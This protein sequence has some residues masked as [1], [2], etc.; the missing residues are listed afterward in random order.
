MKKLILF[1]IPLLMMNCTTPETN[2]LLSKW[3][4]PFQTPPFSLIKAEHYMPAF[5]QGIKEKKA[6]ID[7][8]INTTD[9][10]TFENTLVA[11][12]KAG[13]TINRVSSLFSNQTSS[14][15]NDTLQ[16]LAKEIS[17]LLSALSDDI[18][19]N[20]KLFARI[21]AV[22]NQK[23]QLDLNTEEMR[24]LE[25]TYQDF[26]R[27]G[28][29]LPEEKQTRFR[30][31]NSALSLASL[32]FGDHLLA[33]AN[34]FELVVEDK[35]QLD[36][37]PQNEIDAAASAAKAKGQEGKYIFNINRT[38]L[39]P[40]LT[41]ANNRAL[42]EEL[43]RGYFMKGDNDNKNDNK[44]LIKEI[45]NLRLERA[46]MLGFK[47]HAAYTLDN[48]MAKNAKNVYSLLN[49]V[50][51]AA[52][53]AAKAEVVEMQKIIDKEKGHFQL[54]S[55]DWWH[56][57]EKVRQEKYALS[58]EE[59]RP[60]FQVDNVRQGIFQLANKLYGI[61]FTERPDID[62]Y[63]KDVKAYEVKEA[64]GKHIGIFYTDY[65]ARPSKRSGAWM[66][67]YRKQQRINGENVS[68][69]IVNVCNFPEPTENMPSLL[70]FEQ[71]TTVFHEFGHALHG[72]LSNCEF[73]GLSGTSVARDFVELPSQ[74]MENWASQPEMLKLY[75]K[76]YKTGEIMPQELIDKIVKASQF[77]QG[78]ATTE[79]IAASLLD[80]DYHTQTSPIT[81]VNAFEKKS[82]QEHGLI[83]EI[84]PRYRSTYFQHIFS[85]GYSSGYYSY[86][87]AEVLDADAFN[88]FKEN[89][90]FDKKTAQSFRDNIISKGGSDDPMKLYLQ[91]RGTAPSTTPLLERRGLK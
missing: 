27:G 90:I 4:T 6:D 84:L 74:V 21:K 41:Y 12:D 22:Y 75:A 89:G 20:P 38:C 65:F 10:P 87:W 39:Y 70:T 52:I 61:T 47:N 33:E 77:N 24:F 13:A 62:V 73:Y 68:P 91:F 14:N 88:A 31:I 35:A 53:P 18:N 72:L 11:L 69:I 78:F 76:H 48:K 43:Y 60:Y 45:T 49:E 80:M 59:I 25:T 44:N 28:A 55:W 1:A 56:Y 7:A 40:F 67:S 42:R 32:N 71:V 85:G 86:M 16:A 15:T 5:E 63:Q 26:V 8:I 50:W 30:E 66:T 34:E 37:L 82:M 51:A 2:P 19:L 36:G 64:D 81:D 57:A 17:P 3:D 9:E 46:N 29:N 54:A 58:E 79:Y 23:N 83:D